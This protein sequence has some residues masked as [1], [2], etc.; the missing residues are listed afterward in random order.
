[1][2]EPNNSTTA[3]WKFISCKLQKYKQVYWF[4]N[5]DSQYKSKKGKQVWVYELIA[6]AN[7]NEKAKTFKPK[8]IK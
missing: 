4:S 6:I 3:L 7:Y 1:M 5:M 8:D 2:Q